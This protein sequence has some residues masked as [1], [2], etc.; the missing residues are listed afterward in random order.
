VSET[1]P[2]DSIL[3]CLPKMLLNEQR[4]AL[5][6]VIYRIDLVEVAVARLRL[7]ALWPIP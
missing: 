3:R 4:M 1:L 7:A 5:D 2:D 6:T